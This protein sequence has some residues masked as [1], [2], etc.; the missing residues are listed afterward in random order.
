MDTFSSRP[1]MFRS[2][3]TACYLTILLGFACAVR[4]VPIYDFA[5]LAAEMQRFVQ[6]H[7]LTGASL[8]VA[9][10]GNAVHRQAYGGYTLD[11]RIRIA[12]ASKWLSGLAIA[13]LVE[14]GQM[15]WTDTVGQYFPQAPADKRGITLEQLF[16]HTSGLP[17]TEDSCMSNP[18]YTLA[19]CAEQILQKPLIGAPGKVFAYGGNSMQVAGRMAE[20]AAGKRWD[21]I[22]IDDMA[23]PL[24]LVATDYAT[25]STMQGYVRNTNPRVPGGVRSTLDDYGR[26]MDMVLARGCLA[27]GFPDRCPTGQ[28]FLTS[29]T[30]DTMARDRRVGTTTVFAPPTTTGF[31]Y[32][33][34]QWIENADGVNA[35]IA[36][37]LLSSPGAFGVTPWVDHARG[38]AG[39]VFV[40]NELLAVNADINDLRAMINVIVAD[41]KGRRVRPVLPPAAQPPAKPSAAPVQTPTPRMRAQRR[42]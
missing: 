16:S 13:R 26:V 2:F 12:S 34:G 21:D 30:L 42:R 28:Q 6:V 39:V 11:T 31:G 7:Q 40:E 38:I 32:G 18:L 33:I 4:A 23:L 29:A 20:I 17:P 5:P 1:A 36:Q 14:K 41:G 10:A 9:K 35:Q 15:R 37:P 8:R 25:S 3:L 24:G 19:S 27:G 22:F